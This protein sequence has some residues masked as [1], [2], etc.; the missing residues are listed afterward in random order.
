MFDPQ[1]PFAG[2]ICDWYLG[3]EKVHTILSLCLCFSL[4]SVKGTVYAEFSA[5]TINTP[6]PDDTVFSS[7]DIER[8][9]RA[10]S[11]SELNISA[12]LPPDSLPMGCSVHEPSP[13]QEDERWLLLTFTALTIILSEVSVACSNAPENV[14][15]LLFP[16]PKGILPAEVAIIEPILRF[17]QLLC[18]NHNLLLQVWFLI[19]KGIHLNVFSKC[20]QFLLSVL[21]RTAVKRNKTVYFS[22]FLKISKQQ[23]KL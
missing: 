9:S 5:S 13:Y 10:P 18:E 20:F 4:W 22:E 23:T 6:Q 14:H 3:F 2:H 15:P 8:K 11:V 16:R 21:K 12:T 19:V 7:E 1:I 17:L